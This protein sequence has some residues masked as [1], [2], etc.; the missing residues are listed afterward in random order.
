MPTRNFE[1]ITQDIFNES[2]QMVNEKQTIDELY[3]LQKANLR[4]RPNLLKKSS[5]NIL[6]L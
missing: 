3:G 4:K 5:K 1:Q 6:I 2:R